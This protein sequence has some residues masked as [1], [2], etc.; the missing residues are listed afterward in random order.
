MSD[1]MKMD[2]LLGSY[3]QSLRTAAAPVARPMDRDPNVVRRTIMVIGGLCYS[4][5]AISMITYAFSVAAHL[6]K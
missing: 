4:V 5:V 1:I 2:E 6:G 3:Q